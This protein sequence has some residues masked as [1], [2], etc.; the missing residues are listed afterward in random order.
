MLRFLAH[1]TSVLLGKH[2]GLYTTIVRLLTSQILPQLLCR[3]A[4]GLVLFRSEENFNPQ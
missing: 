3:M 1:T 4:T 2:S